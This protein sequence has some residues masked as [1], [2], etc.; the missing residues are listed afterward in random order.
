ML[1]KPKGKAANKFKQVSLEHSGIKVSSL[2]LLSHAS[3]DTL[4]L[5]AGPRSITLPYF[6]ITAR[7]DI[8]HLELAR[9]ACRAET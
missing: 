3:N 8:Y 4:D 6:E 7:A 2:Q 9:Q 1:T 5:R